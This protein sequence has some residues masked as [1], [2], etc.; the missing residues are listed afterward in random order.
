MRMLKGQEGTSGQRLSKSSPR[1]FVFRKGV[2]WT[3]VIN[4]HMDKPFE[5]FMTLRNEWASNLSCAT[6]ALL[7]FQFFTS[8]IWRFIGGDTG[9][10]VYRS[11]FLWPLAASTAFSHLL[12]SC[13]AWLS[14]GLGGF[15]A[16][17]QKDFLNLFHHVK[18]SFKAPLVYD[19]IHTK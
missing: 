12:P 17:S 1:W 3:F 6:L 10:T 2:V 4:F 7:M 5:L 8:G 19:D 11:I 16:G 15:C 13:S 18:H 14:K 9:N